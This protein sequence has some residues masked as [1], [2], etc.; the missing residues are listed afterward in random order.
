[1]FWQFS[2]GMFNHED[3]CALIE[4]FLGLLDAINDA[5]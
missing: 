2:D 5:K 4:T 1:M 3:S